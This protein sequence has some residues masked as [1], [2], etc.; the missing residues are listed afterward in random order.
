M[1][2]TEIFLAGFRIRIFDATRNDGCRY[3]VN[4]PGTEAERPTLAGGRGGPPA[5]GPPAAGPRGAGAGGFFGAGPKLK[6]SRNPGVP[7]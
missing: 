7:D 3:R 1:L 4:K 5:G 2:S 6:K